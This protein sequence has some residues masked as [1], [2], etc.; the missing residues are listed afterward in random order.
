MLWL[1]KTRCNRGHK[2]CAAV[3]TS[4]TKVS[5]SQQYE[6]ELRTAS[7][8]VHL[9]FP[10]K[11]VCETQLVLPKSL[12]LLQDSSCFRYHSVDVDVES[13]LQVSTRRPCMSELSAPEGN[14]A[15]KLCL[16]ILWEYLDLWVL[17]H[18]HWAWE[19]KPKPHMIFTFFAHY[20]PLMWRCPP[21]PFL[22]PPV[23][24]RDTISLG[25][26]QPKVFFCCHVHFVASD[27]F[28]TLC[29]LHLIP[30]INFL[31]DFFL[32]WSSP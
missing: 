22:T 8:Q 17:H 20:S 26:T 29:I 28:T 27:L 6:W 11:K 14:E 25:T 19:T 1:F 30:V 32:Q 21:S 23:C 24:R 2:Q 13:L 15:Q 31:V 16:L 7:W 12:L 10:G 3:G 18:G 4:K 5:K 9:F